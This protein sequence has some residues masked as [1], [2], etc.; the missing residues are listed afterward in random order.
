[1]N[2]EICNHDFCTECCAG[3]CRLCGVFDPEFDDQGND[4][5]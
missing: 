5:A 4:D 3:E 2:E 1:M